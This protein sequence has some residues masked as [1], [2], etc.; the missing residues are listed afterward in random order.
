[1]TIDIGTEVRSQ[2]TLLDDMVR[3][4]TRLGRGKGVGGRERAG[5]ER[6]L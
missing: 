1:L 2:N 6:V 4:Y 5:E 3:I